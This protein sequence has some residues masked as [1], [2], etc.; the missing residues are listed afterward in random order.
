MGYVI[1]TSLNIFSF[2]SVFNPRCLKKICS[3]S[4]KVLKCIL[5]FCLFSFLFFNL[6]AIF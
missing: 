6:G 1:D 3:L 5:L 2:L 4:L